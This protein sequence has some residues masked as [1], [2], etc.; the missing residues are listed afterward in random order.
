M[1][2]GIM[3]PPT[4]TAVQTPIPDGTPNASAP[5]TD[6]A[7]TDQRLTVWISPQIGERNEIA[8]L[9]LDQQL[10]NFQVSHPEIELVVE[11]K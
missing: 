3:L 5:I 4:A 8:D 9:E 7:E 2:N 11:H 6:T 10:R 1:P